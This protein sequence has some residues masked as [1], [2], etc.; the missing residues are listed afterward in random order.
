M[1]PMIRPIGLASV[2][3]AIAYS[4]V[5]CAGS[6]GAPATITVPPT[7][8][9]VTA[10]PATVTTTVTATTAPPRTT[11]TVAPSPGPTAVD[12]TGNW[13]GTAANPGSPN[14]TW[15]WSATFTQDGGAVTGTFN[16]SG[17]TFPI[18]G[19]SK[20]TTLIFSSSTPTIDTGFEAQIDG[21]SLSGSYTV[22]S[23]NSGASPY[24]K[25][26]QRGTFKGSH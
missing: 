13:F 10:P 8:V 26:P 11:P 3:V 24:G 1:R 2:L 23:P 19:T 21:R 18:K 15:Q 14:S 7:T 6:T 9:I 12:V 4:A 5:S 22:S 16:F 25:N 17:Q 20:G